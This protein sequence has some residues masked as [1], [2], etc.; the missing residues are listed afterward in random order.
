MRRYKDAGFEPLPGYQLRYVL[1][2]DRSWID[3]LTVP[4][5]PFNEIAKVGAQMY[6]GKRAGSI[7]H[8]DVADDQSAEGGA[9]PT[10]ALH[11]SGRCD[12]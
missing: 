5:L 3:R 7:E 2:L 6:L 11:P 1:F 8:D 10:P 9:S 12:P 4:I